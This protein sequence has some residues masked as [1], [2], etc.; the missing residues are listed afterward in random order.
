MFSFQYIIKAWDKFFFEERPTEGIAIFRILWMGI[1]LMYFLIDLGNVHDFYGPEAIISQ[2]T[3]NKEFPFYHANLFSFFKESYT[4]T[5]GIIIVFGMSL[6]TSVLG[7]LTRSSLLIALICMTSIHQRNIW[8]LS[9]SELLM[10]TMTLLLIVSP[11]GHTLSLDS[12][13]GRKYPAFKKERN[14]P[15]WSLRLIQIQISVIYLWTVWHKL[16]G[17][18]WFEGTA[19]YYATRL[20]SMTNST[21]PMIL[22]SVQF[23]K[24]A[25]WGTLLVELALGTLVWFKEFRKPVIIIGILFHI[26]IEYVMSIP[27]FELYMMSLFVNFFTP[28]EHKHFIEET[29]KSFRLVSHEPQRG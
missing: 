24:L 27:F 13:L 25:T 22:D 17:E 23:L 26:S 12:Y 20:E 6:I 3:S 15:V 11:C 29:F 9:S 21:I 7:L 4:I 18:T 14:W 2:G 16:K 8:L 28:E 5:Y 1:S 19:V 10:R